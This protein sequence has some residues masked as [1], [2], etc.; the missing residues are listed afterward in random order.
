MISC[1][2]VASVVP[3]SLPP[4]IVPTQFIVDRGHI[5]AQSLG[6]NN[7]DVVNLFP[8]W[9]GSNRFHGRWKRWETALEA[10]LRLPACTDS[11]WIDISFQPPCTAQ[12]W[13]PQRGVYGVTIGCQCWKTMR[14]SKAP[15]VKAMVN[16]GDSMQT[17]S[18]CG[19][20]AVASDTISISTDFVNNPIG[21]DMKYGGAQFSFGAAV[22]APPS[23]VDK[24]S[25]TLINI[26]SYSAMSDEESSSQEFDYDAVLGDVVS[27]VAKM[28]TF[29]PAS[30]RFTDDRSI[31][32]ED[33]PFDVTSTLDEIFP[34]A[35]PGDMVVLY[36][37]VG[38][39]VQLTKPP[40]LSCIGIEAVRRNMHIMS[41]NDSAQSYTPNSPTC[42]L[43]SSITVA[44]FPVRTTLISDLV[45]M[46]KFEYLLRN[47]STPS[48]TR[49]YLMTFGELLDETLTWGDYSFTLQSTL[50]LLTAK[51]RI[52]SRGAFIQSSCRI[53][54]T[55]LQQLN[56]RGVF[57]P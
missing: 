5:V 10:A 54:R 36:F 13:V 12:E 28:K 47:P 32:P 22:A 41:I 57:A 53:A 30:L 52:N 24:I 2:T 9:A 19:A 16:W 6:G 37:Y 20:S 34:L 49:F 14:K 40:D 48:D 38:V 31:A 7:D 44:L 27:Q 29:A 11:I 35:A 33:M 50:Q 55:I 3:S 43:P 23:I 42:T 21:D 4:K 18:A 17:T 25:L 1:G 15:T 26:D 51:P 46:A 45:A 8:Q 56:C 39:D